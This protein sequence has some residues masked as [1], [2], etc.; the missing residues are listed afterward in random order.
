FTR[1]D[2]CEW[3]VECNPD[4][5]TEEKI[6]ALAASGV[7]RLSLGVQSFSAQT[8]SVLGRRGELGDLGRLLDRARA[9]GILHHSMDLIYAVPGQTVIQW[10]D[11]LA[12]AVEFGI[13]H[14]SAYALTVEE[15]TRL[16][17]EKLPLVDD[18]LFCELWDTTDQM[19]AQAGLHRYEV[20]NFS[21]PGCACR[22]NLDIW[23]GGTYL[24][25]GPAAVSFDGRDR[26]ANSADLEFW[27]TGGAPEVDRLPS[28]ERLSE[29]FAFGFRTLAGWNVDLF[30]EQ[31]GVEVEAFFGA[32]L[33]SLT[34]AGLVERRGTTIG[35]T[36]RGLLLNDTLVAQLLFRRD[37]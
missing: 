28:E 1:E 34:E 18:T 7:T 21:R 31:F 35:P 33:A 22:H 4:S 36:R 3:T 12:R 6:G 24:G 19:L 23:Q 2:S 14:L 16:A 8:R 10:A 37:S 25:L 13:D 26:F 30:T 5:L 32:E 9:E 20:S 29:I 17:R 11:D 15:G 27:L